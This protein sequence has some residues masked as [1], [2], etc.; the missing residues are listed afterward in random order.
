MQVP[1]AAVRDDNGRRLADV[2]SMET[3]ARTGGTRC[4]GWYRASVERDT[5]LLL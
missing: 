2:D 1:V 3:D 5:S 4:R